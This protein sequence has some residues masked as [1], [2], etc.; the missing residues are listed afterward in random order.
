MG[1]EPYTWRRVRTVRRQA[2]RKVAWRR[3]PSLHLVNSKKRETAN[4]ISLK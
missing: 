2:V 3:Q 4:K 1:G